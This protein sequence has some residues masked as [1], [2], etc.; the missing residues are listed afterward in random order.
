MKVLLL[1]TG[2]ECRRAAEWFVTNGHPVIG[3]LGD[4]IVKKTADFF[5]ITFYDIKE[6]DEKRLRELAPDVI[7][8]YLYDKKIREPLLSFAKYGCINFHPALLPEYKGRGGCNFAILDKKDIWGATA[9][10]ADAGFDTGKIIRTSQFSFDYRLETA[11]SLKR[12]TI[13]A[14][15]DLLKSVILDIEQ[16]GRLDSKKQD[17]AVGK[18]YSRKDMLQNMEIDLEKDDIDTKIQ[19]FW[20]PPYSGAYI[21]IK[22]QKYTLV[23]KQI[24]ENLKK[25][26]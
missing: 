20:Y 14:M 18:Y 19:A 13:E 21:E 15:F 3:M 16:K 12:R 4:D 17:N 24:L 7:I 2:Q 9:H 23:N 1:G 5:H 25:H 10:Y 8:S 6:I 26:Q 11:V 22:G